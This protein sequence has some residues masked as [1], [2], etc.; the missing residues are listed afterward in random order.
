MD[1]I[2]MLRAK[3]AAA[4]ARV[5]AAEELYTE[6]MRAS[7]VAARALAE[8]VLAR[9]EER[10]AL[11]MAR[12]QTAVAEARDDDDYLVLTYSCRCGSRWASGRGCSCGHQEPWSD[13]CEV[14]ESD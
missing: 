7:G 1:T 9:N 5:D 10:N 4:N 12:D 6:A 2:G 3:L 11:F 8:T 14:C 13:I